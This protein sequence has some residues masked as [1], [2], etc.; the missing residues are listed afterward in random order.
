[1]SVATITTKAIVDRWRGT[2]IGA[3][4][5]G[6]FLL[7]G[8]AAYRSIDLTMYERMPQA[9]RDLMGIP[10]GADVASL[11]YG[12]IYSFYG[13]LILAGIAIAA[14]SAAIAGEERRGTAAILLANPASR[15]RV[16][17]GKAASLVVLM[18][19]GA[20]IL[21]LAGALSPGSSTST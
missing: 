5:I 2:V 18:V 13:A 14:G 6:V 17:L 12:A 11:A 4:T 1:M 9:V 10:A 3:V 16:V 15:T 20:V 19:V 8:M 7:G 21:W